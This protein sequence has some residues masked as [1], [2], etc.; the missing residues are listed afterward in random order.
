VEDKIKKLTLKN[1]SN[2][3]DWSRCPKGDI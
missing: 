3:H 2:D 1:L